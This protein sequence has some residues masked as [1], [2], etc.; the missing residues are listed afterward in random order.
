MAASSFSSAAAS[1]SARSHGLCDAFGNHGARECRRNGGTRRSD[2]STAQLEPCSSCSACGAG[3]RCACFDRAAEAT[4][5]GR[6]CQSAW[7][8]VLGPAAD[9]TQ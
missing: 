8:Q 5:G 2:W 1:A 7:R 6:L 9:P 4:W 3:D